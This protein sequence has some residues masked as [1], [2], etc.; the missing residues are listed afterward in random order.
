M[1]LTGLELEVTTRFHARPGAEDALD[2]AVRGIVPLVR[3]EPHC[4]G[5][6]AYR[7]TDDRRLFVI[8]SRWS[9]EAAYQRHH[10]LARTKEFLEL[11]QSLV[12]E[13]IR[14]DRLRAIE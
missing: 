4:L 5:V 8:A 13:P 10:A 6:R 7:A 11:V 12:D 9:E 2:R 14:S 3:E 1:A